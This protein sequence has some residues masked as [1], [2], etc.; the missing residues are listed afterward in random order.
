MACLNSP[1]D[2]SQNHG[3]LQKKTQ[4]ILVIRAFIIRFVAYITFY[5]LSRASPYKLL[6]MPGKLR[7]QFPP[8]SP[9]HFDSVSFPTPPPCLVLILCVSYCTRFRYTRQFTGTK[10]PPPCLSAGIIKFDS[11]LQSYGSFSCEDNNEEKEGLVVDKIA[12][13][14][15]YFRVS[16]V[17]PR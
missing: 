16:S 10:N 7:A 15:L 2:V 14:R 5:L 11:V 13:E 17:Y 4:I 1:V 9:R 8:D 3:L 6:R 12:L